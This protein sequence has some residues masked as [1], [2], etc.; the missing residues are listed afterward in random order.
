MRDAAKKK[1]D[2]Q[3]AQTRSHLQLAHPDAPDV[4]ALA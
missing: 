1:S 3:D 2:D 4:E